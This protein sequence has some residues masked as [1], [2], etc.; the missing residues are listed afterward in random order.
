MWAQRGRGRVR[1][2][3]RDEVRLMRL[4]DDG[5]LRFTAQG[6]PFACRSSSKFSNHSIPHLIVSMTTSLELLGVRCIHIDI[7]WPSYSAVGLG[8][9]SANLF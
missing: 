6:M 3:S 8:V 2:C 5:Y 7:K 9:F 4:V 1:H